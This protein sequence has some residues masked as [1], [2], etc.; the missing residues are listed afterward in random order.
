MPSERLSTSLT[1]NYQAVEKMLFESA[2]NGLDSALDEMLSKAQKYAPVRDIFQS[3][4][5]GNRRE[6]VPRGIQRRKRYKHQQKVF[7]RKIRHHQDMTRDRFMA[8]VKAQRPKPFRIKHGGK[9]IEASTSSFDPIL[10][11]RD[12]NG[13][14]AKWIDQDGNTRKG[15]V[16]AKGLRGAQVSA[17]RVEMIGAS[18]INPQTGEA[19]TV[20]AGRFLSRRGRAELKSST[21]F[22]K[23]LRDQAKMSDQQIES[24]VKRSSLSYRKAHKITGD[25]SAGE[26]L[27][28]RR[29]LH[30]D[31]AGNI[32]VGGRLRDEIYR[33]QV[34]Q[35]G[36]KLYGDVVS[37]TEYAKYQEYGT[38]HNRAHP[39]MRP[40]LYDMRGRFQQIVAR[41]MRTRGMK[42]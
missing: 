4:R 13:K 32:S 8:Q 16:Y 31:A 21:R 26:K 22:T 40:A 20:G 37:P 39:Y 41:S 1:L 9:R 25:L 35:S 34:Y 23:F 2:K 36:S 30:A 10:R 6:Y 18:L 12:E 19:E 29:G 38:S 42:R 33:T 11:W 15:R 14:V 24:L 5:H 7:G 3:D 27:T 17:G 28:R